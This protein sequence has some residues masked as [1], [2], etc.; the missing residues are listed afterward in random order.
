MAAAALSRL[1]VDES[2]FVVVKKRVTRKRTF[3]EYSKEQREKVADVCGALVKRR[4]L[5]EPTLALKSCWQSATNVKKWLQELVAEEE[6]SDEHRRLVRSCDVAELASY[7]LLP[8]MYSTKKRW[9]VFACAKDGGRGGRNS[10][11]VSGGHVC[12]KVV[13]VA[14]KKRGLCQADGCRAFACHNSSFCRWHN[15]RQPQSVRFNVDVLPPKTPTPRNFNYKTISNKRKI[16]RRKSIVD[17]KVDKGVW[18]K[19]EWNKY[20]SFFTTFCQ[21]SIAW[22]NLWLW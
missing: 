16:A 20:I 8:S 18:A 21:F 13:N 9:Y 15:V 6:F 12:Q 3:A 4:R 11:Q 10:S 17:T 1:S 7:N 5:I 19:K 22:R 2:S 14:K